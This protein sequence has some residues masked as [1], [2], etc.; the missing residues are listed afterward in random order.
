RTAPTHGQR[1]I[2]IPD[3]ASTRTP[4]VSA[5]TYRSPSGVGM[6]AAAQSRSP[7][8]GRT[9]TSAQPSA[10]GAT[11]STAIGSRNAGPDAQP[12]QRLLPNGRP[13]ISHGEPS[14]E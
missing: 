11:P 6:T 9:R 13:Y 2:V 3:G 7:S 10:T 8:S 4:S 12:W 14:G 1:L 5:S